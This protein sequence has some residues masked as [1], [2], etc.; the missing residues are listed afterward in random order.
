MRV[1]WC[2]SRVTFS[3]SRITQHVPCP[4]F[5]VTSPS[6]RLQSQQRLMPSVSPCL[7]SGLSLSRAL[8]RYLPF[9]V[10]PACC[11][12]AGRFAYPSHAIHSI[13]PAQARTWS[14][15]SCLC[16]VLLDRVHASNVHR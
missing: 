16:V 12:S 11:V 10:L 3:T 7:Q 9:P 6:F 14:M 5:L 8:R 13:H 1:S 4:T 15:R 2:V